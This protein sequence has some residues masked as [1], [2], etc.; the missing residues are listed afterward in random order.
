MHH[1]DALILRNA[2]KQL[3]SAMADLKAGGPVAETMAALSIAWA[4]TDIECVLATQ[5]KE[6]E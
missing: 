3:D 1:L 4:K 2:V 6:T 5:I